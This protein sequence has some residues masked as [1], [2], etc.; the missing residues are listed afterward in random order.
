MYERLTF[1]ERLT[2]MNR[3]QMVSFHQDFWYFFA[4]PV[5]L[6]PL[7]RFVSYRSLVA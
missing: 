4:L 2:L 3:F 5:L 7:F 1:F 6:R